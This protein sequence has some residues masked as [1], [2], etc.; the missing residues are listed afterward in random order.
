[1]S[2]KLTVPDNPTPAQLQH[3]LSVCSNEIAKLADLVA[4]YKQDAAIKTTTY[5][6]AMARAIVKNQGKGNVSLVKSLAELDEEVI[7]ATDEVDMTEAV[8]ALAKAELDGYDAL[9]VALRKI[10]EIRK[11]E[12]NRIHG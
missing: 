3:L 12:M 10:A 5:K 2:T 6:R 8:Y 4:T 1:M 11:T 9:F 7:K